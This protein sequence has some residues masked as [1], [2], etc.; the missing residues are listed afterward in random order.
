MASAFPVT[1]HD[2]VE[3]MACTQTL[4]SL[5]VNIKND[6]RGQLIVNHIQYFELMNKIGFKSTPVYL[7]PT[8]IVFSVSLYSYFGLKLDFM[9]ALVSFMVKLCF[10]W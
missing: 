5:K 10:C 1:Y 2:K 3:K 8:L 6:F 7:V 9:W 4:K